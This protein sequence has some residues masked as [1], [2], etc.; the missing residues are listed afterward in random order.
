MNNIKQALK[1]AEKLINKAIMFERE[2]EQY[3]SESN[4][5]LNGCLGDCSA[6]IYVNGK[7]VL[8]DVKAALAELEQQQQWVE[9]SDA[10]IFELCPYIDHDL[11]EEAF[12]RGARTIEA[13]LKELNT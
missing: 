1:S 6:D 9:L 13:K 8:A 11:L 3:L 4:Y 7:Q 2:A 12:Y 10:E 5:E